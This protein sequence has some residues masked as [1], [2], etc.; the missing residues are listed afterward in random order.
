[1][2]ILWF[3]INFLEPYLEKTK[4]SIQNETIKIDYKTIQEHVYL[5]H[6][7]IVSINM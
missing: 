3:N 7:L 4:Y 5:K 6:L 1:M 2:V